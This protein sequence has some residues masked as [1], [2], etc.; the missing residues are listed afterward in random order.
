MLEL[1]PTCGNCN[2]AL[3]PD[4]PEARIRKDPASTRVRHKLLD[5]AVHALF[6]AAIRG[7]AP[8]RR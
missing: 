4:A 7:I 2:K 6:A 8:E 1:R 3:P 5:P